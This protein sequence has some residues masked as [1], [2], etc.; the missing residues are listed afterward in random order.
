MAAINTIREA[1]NGE[2]VP[3]LLT[4]IL[5]LGKEILDYSTSMDFR[6]NPITGQPPHED[7]TLKT[8][9]G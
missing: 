4:D 6:P 1:I 7:L 3:I 9:Q 5:Y 2:E 8:W